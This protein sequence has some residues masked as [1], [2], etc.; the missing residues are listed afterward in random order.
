[1]IITGTYKEHKKDNIGGIFFSSQSVSNVSNISLKKTPIP[2][3]IVEKLSKID[4]AEKKEK[5]YGINDITLKSFSLGD[6]AV[7]L[8]G[9]FEK[10]ILGDRHS[11]FVFSNILNI[12]FDKDGNTIFSMAPKLRVSASKV[13]GAF[14]YPVVFNNKIVVLYNDNVKNLERNIDESPNRYDKYNNFALIAA[15][16]ERDGSVKREVVIDQNKEDYLSL[17][18]NAIEISASSFLIPFVHI[19]DLGQIKKGRKSAIVVLN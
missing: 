6:G 4:F 17:P 9:Q 14:S 7:A 13:V 3:N 12:Y 18:D 11:F 10:T 1:L 15:T 5:Y 2:L 16:F 19:G 8:A